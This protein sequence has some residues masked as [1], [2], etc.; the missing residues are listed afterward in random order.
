MDFNVIENEKFIHQVSDSLAQLTIKKLLPVV[1][2]WGIKDEYPQLSE[3][4]MKMSLPLQSI[5]CVRPD[6]L[7]PENIATD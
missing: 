6:F 1:F 5:F 3:K 4:A 7:Q 2:W